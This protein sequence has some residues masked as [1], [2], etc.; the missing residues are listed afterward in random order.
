M[1]FKQ[2][3]WNYPETNIVPE[4][5]WLEDEFLFGEAYFQGLLLLVLER[6]PIFLEGIMKLAIFFGRGS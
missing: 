1:D 6:V 2:R 4:N 5:G 3:S